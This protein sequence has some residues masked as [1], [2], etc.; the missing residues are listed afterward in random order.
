GRSGPE[1]RPPAA[2]TGPS[3]T[4][5]STAAAVPAPPT[6]PARRA[7]AAP[8]ATGVRVVLIAGARASR[9]PWH[10][11][12]GAPPRRG[13]GPPPSPPRGGWRGRGRRVAGRRSPPPRPRPR[14][15][16][17]APP[18]RPARPARVP[19]PPGPRRRGRDRESVVEGGRVHDDAPRRA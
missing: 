6:W 19:R 8:T 14:P 11:R 16:R 4:G 13:R 5:G 7:R 10:P 1:S 15:R 9:R 2:G 12:R 3:I 17:R 18:H